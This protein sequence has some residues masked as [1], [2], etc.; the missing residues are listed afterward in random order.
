MQ[1]WLILVLLLTACSAGLTPNNKAQNLLNAPVQQWQ[2]SLGSQSINANAINGISASLK[3]FQVDDSNKQVYAGNLLI[4]AVSGAVSSEKVKV[5]SGHAYRF[6]ISFSFTGQVFAYVDVIKDISGDKQEIKFESSDIKYSTNSTET[7][8]LSADITAGLIP[9]LDEDDEWRDAS[10][11]TSLRAKG[12][13]CLPIVVEGK[14][15]AAM[16]AASPEPMPSF[17]DE[18]RHVYTQISQQT[19]VILQNI[20]L[21]NQTRRRLDEVN[22][23]L[24]FSRG[25]SGMDADS[26]VES[27]LASARRVIPHAHAGV[28]LVWNSKTEH[29]VPRAVSGYADN[30]SM[31]KINYRL[32]EALPGTAFL[33]RKSRRVDEINFPR[34]YNLNT[35]NLAHYRQATGGRLP[36]SCLIMPI[37]SAEQNLGLLVLDNF[38]TTAAFRPD[39]ETLLVSLSQQVALSLD[40]M[41][42]VQTSQ[43]RAGQLQ[44]LND[45]SAS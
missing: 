35:E 11:L 44:A 20:S 13:I 9:N 16:L 5:L 27:L 18:D 1:Y 28:V 7:N 26:V 10:L 30:D 25:L 4:D 3:I 43:E 21:L 2:T 12:V 8:N 33:N 17:T 34:D 14:P 40:N 45:A 31:M 22:L 38:N 37:V 36:V 32:G 41:R 39:D 29:L 42:L 24:E 19:S 15:V 23:L 6:V